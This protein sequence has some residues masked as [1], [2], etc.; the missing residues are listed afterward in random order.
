[1]NNTLKKWLPLVGIFCGTLA[2]A[3]SNSDSSYDSQSMNQ[4]KQQ[5]MTQITPPAQPTVDNGVGFSIFADY[6]LWEARAGN[7]AFAYD[8][9]PQAASGTST[10]GLAQGKAY[11]PGFKYSSGFKVGAS[12]ELGFDN[13]DLEAQ[14]IWLRPGYKQTKMYA[15][16]TTYAATTAAAEW[17]NAPS[18]TRLLNATGQWRLNYNLVQLNMG[19][20]YMISPN[21]SFRNYYGI[22]GAW[23]NQKNDTRYFFGDSTSTASDATTGRTNYQVWQRQN[24]W[25]V[26]FQTGVDTAWMFDENWSIYANF[27]TS[28]LWG[29]FNNRNQVKNTTANPDTFDENWRQSNYG[30]Q[31]TLDIEMGFR[32]VMTFDDNSYAFL[33]QAG[34]EQQIWFNQVR[35]NTYV[36]NYSQGDLSIQGFNLR[37]RFYF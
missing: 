33:L 36:S 2:F 3:A 25:G 14:Y 32:W 22:R 13:W 23:F 4:K 35:M 9:M 37:A 19:R 17:M 5:P 16:D 29:R 18:G 31:P 11:N 1:M 6:I 21:L 12:A 15:T 27:G 30:L 26:G 34:W 10:A 8:G 7:T 20:N 28:L 24:W